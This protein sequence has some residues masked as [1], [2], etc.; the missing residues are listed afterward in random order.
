MTPAPAASS[1]QFSPALSSPAQS[2]S[3]PASASRPSWLVPLGLSALLAPLGLFSGCAS[4]SD[5]ST[6]VSVSVRQFGIAQNGTPT[7]LWTVRGD[8]VAFD[9]TD[10]GATLVAVRTADRLGVVDDVVLGFDSVRG[11]ESPANQYFG[12]TTG[13]VCNR[14]GGARFVLDGTEYAL[15][16]NDGAHTLHGGGA[17][18]LS[19]LSWRGEALRDG[20]RFT[21]RSNDGDEGFPGTLDVTVSYRL[22]SGGRIEVQSE[23]RSDRRTPVNLTNHSY[24]NLGGT[25]ATTADDRRLAS[26]LEHQLQLAADHYTPVDDTL[27]PTGAIAPVAGTPLDFTTARPLSLWFDRVLDTATKGYDHNFVLRSANG[28]R[29]VARLWDPQSHRSL[30]VW[31]DQPGLQLYTGNFLNGQ[32]GKQGRSYPQRSAVCLET[33]HFPDSVNKPQFPTTILEPGA[34]YRTV[35]VFELSVADP[36]TARSL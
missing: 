18:A 14:I 10:L 36:V 15:T 33:Q 27:I 25:G 35:T 34:T 28:L 11:Y 22:L 19:R 23:A 16:R 7:R 9:V 5:S 24:W 4:M 30:R 2:S 12:C 20:V 31:T 13:R 3:A 29:P 6:A 21:C 26:V 1:T 17:R 8:G 32:D